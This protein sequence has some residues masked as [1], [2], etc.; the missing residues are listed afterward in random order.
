MCTVLC[1]KME[2]ETRRSSTRPEYDCVE[3]CRSAE[4]LNALPQSDRWLIENG[5]KQADRHKNRDH[6]GKEGDN[7]T[8]MVSKQAAKAVPGS[9]PG[10]SLIAA[11]MT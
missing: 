8:A 3:A 6:P 2:A 11:S 1:E 5:G 7:K 9:L 10:P 4:K